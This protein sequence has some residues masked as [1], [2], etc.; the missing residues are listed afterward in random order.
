MEDA[1]ATEK[2]LIEQSESQKRNFTKGADEDET[3]LRPANARTTQR[4]AGDILRQCSLELIKNVNTNLIEK[5]CTHEWYSDYDESKLQSFKRVIEDYI[6]QNGD[7]VFDQ[8]GKELQI[9]PVKYHQK[10]TEVEQYC[11]TEA[12]R[13]VNSTFIRNENQRRLAKTEMMKREETLKKTFEE[14]EKEEKEKLEEEIQ[15]LNAE[16]ETRMTW[17]ETKKYREEHWQEI[18]QELQAKY[19]KEHELDMKIRDALLRQR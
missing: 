19:K 16:P 4:R 14:I 7:A 15:A 9:D 2:K 13:I 3:D 6:A 8:F 12:L 5:T 17:A 10:K 1:D 18:E 11:V